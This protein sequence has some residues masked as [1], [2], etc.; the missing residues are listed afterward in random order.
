MVKDPWN[1]IW[2]IATRKGPLSVDA[3]RTRHDESDSP[4]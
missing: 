1:N 2:Q 3:I 4:Q